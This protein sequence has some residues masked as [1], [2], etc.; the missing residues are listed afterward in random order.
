MAYNDVF[1][2][3]LVKREKNG[4]DTM[5]K[6]GITVAAVVLVLFLSMIPM[7][8][9]TGLMFPLIVLIG[10]LA[11]AF[12]RRLNQEFEYIF[13]NGEL[14]IDRIYNKSKRKRALSVDVRSMHVI[15]HVKHSDYKQETSQIEKVLDFSSGV[16]SD[17]LYAG[18]MDYEGKRTMILFE[19]NETVLKSIKMYIPRKIKN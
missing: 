12:I 2:E 5:K 7:I 14:D 11:V 4:K 16:E 10:W 3:Q 15:V 17:N 9:R 1:K 6:V 19:P 13:T 8:V 18:I